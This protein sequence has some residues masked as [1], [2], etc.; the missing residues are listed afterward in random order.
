MTDNLKVLFRNYSDTDTTQRI[1]PQCFCNLQICQQTLRH[2]LSTNE[3]KK[4]TLIDMMIIFLKL[5]LYIRFRVL[6]DIVLFKSCKLL[7]SINYT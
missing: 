1:V 7:L 5:Q 6:K 4:K 3:N 2:K